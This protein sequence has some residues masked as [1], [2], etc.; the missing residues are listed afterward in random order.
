[1]ARNRFVTPEVVRLTLSQGDWIDVKKELNAGE[2]RR[3]FTDLVKVMHAGE[4][5][6]LQPDRVG[7]TQML[8]YIVGWS[9]RGHDDKPVPFSEAAL[10][11]LDQ[12]SYTEI[13]EAIDKHVEGV[14]RARTLRKNAQDTSMASSA[15]SA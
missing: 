12:D 11:N 5:A 7:K 6:E 14:D 1:M 8:A 2:E 3:F 10:D 15:T 9:F 4:R 13:F